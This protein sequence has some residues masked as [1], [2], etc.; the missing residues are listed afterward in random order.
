MRYLQE[1]K[2]NQYAGWCITEE[3]PFAGLVFLRKEN[4]VIV[5]EKSGATRSPT[6]RELEQI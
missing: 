6:Q 1:E 5:V 4:E 2:V 3:W